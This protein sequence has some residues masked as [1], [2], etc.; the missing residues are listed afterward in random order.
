MRITLVGL[1]LLVGACADVGLQFEP[2]EPPQTFDNLLRVRGEQCVQPD[3]TLDFPVKVL[4]MLDQSSSFQCTDPMRN[5][6]DAIDD[7]ITRILRQRS[8]SVGLVGF[9]EWSRTVPFTTERGDLSDRLADGGG[10]ATDFQGA[11]AAGL[12]VLENDMLATSPGERARTRYVVL[13]V[14]DGLPEPRCRAGCE[15]GASV[16]DPALGA[17]FTGTC[18][19]GED[20]DG[21]GAV[22][23]GDRDCQDPDLLDPPFSPCNF[24]GRSDLPGSIEDDEYVDFSGVCP[25]YNQP[26]QRQQRVRD[27]LELQEIYN[28][29]SISLNSVL[30]FTTPAALAATCG[31]GAAEAFGFDR[32]EASSILRGMAEAGRGAFRDVDVSADATDF[33]Q[34]DFQALFAPQR[35]TGLTV[36]N[37]FARP[38]ASGFRPDTDRDGVA[39]EDELADDMRT[40]PADVDTDAD[41]YTD[42]VERRLRESGFDARDPGSPPI[43]C[44]DTED[45]DGDGLRNCEETII[46]T[47]LRLADTDGDTLVDWLEVVSGLDPLVFDSD[48]D[49]DFDGNLNREEVR[50]GT[51]PTQ[52]DQDRFRFEANRYRVDD[53][54]MVETEA[55]ERQ[56]YGFDVQNIQLVETPVVG[57]R[58]LN[59]IMIHAYEQPAMLS[60]SDGITQVACFEVF[61]NGETDKVP[62]DGVV[63]ASQEGWTA[64]LSA[65]QTGVDSLAACPWLGEGFNRR[66][67]LNQVEACMPEDVTLG[68]FRFSNNEAQALIRSYIAGNLGQQLPLE[69][70]R[71]FRPIENFDPDRD[72]VRPWEVDLLLEFFGQIEQACACMPSDEEDAPPLSPCCDS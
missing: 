72:C 57:N 69:S 8:S 13:F 62:E 54:G 22:D 44:E 66:R 5:R 39:D 55:G 29:G 50:A 2:P 15:D 51:D 30:V 1:A 32:V 71:L 53:L 60:G 4:I 36:F 38:A 18:D 23:G 28:V 11:L 49:I 19:N 21:D 46:G 63:D 48:L 14:S 10:S 24:R 3:N 37:E 9:S 7:A 17:F 45:T 41:G 26:E 20:D 27:M 34:F 16:N 65:I 68:R 58:G 40:D 35:L 33:L 31:A 59:R 6:F 67:L 47:D 52:Q 43:A 64:M 61:Y 25:D 70:W 42:G 56:C 12:Q